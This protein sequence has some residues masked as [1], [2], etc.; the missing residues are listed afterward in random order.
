MY[1]F[2]LT[3]GKRFFLSEQTDIKVQDVGEVID[4]TSTKTIEKGEL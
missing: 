2:V 4:V 3:L 1:L